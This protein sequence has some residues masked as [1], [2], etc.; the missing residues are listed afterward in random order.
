MAV[1]SV[2]QFPCPVCS[3]TLTADVT[4]VGIPTVLADGRLHM[5]VAFSMQEAS[6]DHLYAAAA[7]N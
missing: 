1:P 6:V 2:V 4:E 7:M 5:N 3:F